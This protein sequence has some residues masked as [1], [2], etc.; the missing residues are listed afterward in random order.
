MKARFSAIALAGC[1][2]AALGIAGCGTSSDGPKGAKKVAVTLVDSGCTP[3][4]IHVAAGPDG[5]L[6]FTESNQGVIGRITTSGLVTQYSIPVFQAQP[7]GIV[8]E[9]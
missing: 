5:A 4:E 2:V 7:S 9:D 3:T 8:L 1:A 6:W